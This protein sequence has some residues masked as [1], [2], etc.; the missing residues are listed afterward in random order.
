MAVAKTPS[1][2][3]IEP[4]EEEAGCVD[5]FLWIGQSYPQFYC[6]RDASCL[7]ADRPQGP[8]CFVHEAE[9][10]GIS[11][12]I[13]RAAPWAIPGR[14]RIFLAHRGGEADASKGRIFGYFV[15]NR[16]E[17]LASSD[18]LAPAGANQGR[19]DG[20]LKGGE[21]DGRAGKHGPE[22]R[23]ERC[24]NGKVIVTHRYD[25]ARKRWVPTGQRC[26]ELPEPQ[27]CEEG[28]F[29]YARSED[30][31]WI[32]THACVDGEWQPTGAGDSERIPIEDELLVEHRGCSFREDPGAVYLVDGLAAEIGDA[33]SARLAR[34]PVYEPDGEVDPERLASI[35]EAGRKVF[36]EVVDEVTRERGSRTRVPAAL[37]GKASVHGELVLFDDPPLFEKHPQAWFRPLEHIDG[38][39]LF[40][41]IAAG[42]PKVSVH[43]CHRRAGA[44]SQQEVIAVLAERMEANKAFTE[45]LLTELAE[46]AR[47]E[48]RTY[49]K[50]RV[51]GLG[52][53]KEA[54]GQLR[55][56]FYVQRDA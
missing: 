4:S 47:E 33:F 28:D 25:K 7:R 51:P 32:A 50:F 22:V 23:T 44:M 20:A 30:G 13:S 14:T 53:L 26:P 41:Q 16:T 29:A 3:A 27:E 35:R 21:S 17:Q 48:L 34:E 6:H 11:R 46:L 1:A 54:D 38:D 18:A 40:A 24:W 10:R 2:R 45:R 56:E 5:G 8:H 9:R 43:G 55:L 37:R 49:E 42:A 12:R 15:L 31:E 52:M 19:R 36:N 39:D